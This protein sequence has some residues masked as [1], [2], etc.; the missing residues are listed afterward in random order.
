MNK[1]ALITGGTRGI[2]LGIAKCLAREGYSLALNGMRPAAAVADVLDSLRAGGGDVAYFAGDVGKRAT[3]DAMLSGIRDRF[4]GLNVLVNNAGI[5]S[6]GRM[7]VLDADEE[8]FDAVIST[9]LRGPFFLTKQAA[10][11]MVDQKNSQ[12][13]FQGCVINVG[14][15]SST[16]VSVNRADYCIAK[17]GLSMMT[18]IYAARLGRHDIPVFEV[19]PGVIKTDMTAGVQEKYDRLIADGLCVTPRW[20]LPEDTGKAVAALARGD[21]A[22]ST[23]QVILVDGGLTLP[24]L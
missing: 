12:P 9:N 7:D 6:P 2:G 22:Y 24:R 4:G 8:A 23:G 13:S 3:H 16:V 14:S 1:V 18:Q 19:R 15:I 11:W 17:A 20:G 5:T 10:N 21:F